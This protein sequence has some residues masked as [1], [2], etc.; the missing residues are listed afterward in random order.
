ML[1][2]KVK[3]EIQDLSGRYFDKRAV[4]IM[5]LHAIRREKAS[6]MPEDFRELAEILDEHPA[7]IESTAKFYDMFLL[8]KP[9]RCT[10]GVC[11][12][13]SCMLRGSDKIVE[14]LKSTLGVDFGVCTPDGSFCFEEVECL[15][16]CEMAPAVTVNDEAMG[17]MTVEQLDSVIHNCRSGKPFSEDGKG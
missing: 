14:H 6:F 4:L 15:G 7:E 12:S 16:A 13:V 10:I 17:P 1:S 11:T 2:E 5:A 8:A 9:A 3:Q